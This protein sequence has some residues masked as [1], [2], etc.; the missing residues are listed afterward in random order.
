[1]IKKILFI[2][3]T[4]SFDGSTISFLNLVKDIRKLNIEV[5]VVYKYTKS[6]PNFGGDSDLVK[7]LKK[8]GCKTIGM[9]LP[10]YNSKMNRG[11]INLIIDVSKIIAKKILSYRKLKRLFITENPDIVH[12]NNDNIYDGY[13]V[14]RVLKIPHIWHMREY[15]TLD[16]NNYILPS[17]KYFE[18]LLKG[19]YTV[20]IT[21]DIKK[22]YNLDNDKKDFVFYNPTL[23]SEK[24]LEIYN[25]NKY[26]LVANRLCSEKGIEDIIRAFAV[27]YNKHDNYVLKLL[28]FEPTKGYVDKLRQLCE[29]L[30]ITDSVEFLGYTEDV[31]SYMSNANAL[32]V[33]SYYEGFGR[34]TAEANM[35][36]LPV[37][38]RNT[39]GTKEI[40]ELTGGGK[41][42][43]TI[44]EM[45]DCMEYFAAM[46]T[47]EIRNFMEK[48]RKIA[49][50]SF[51]N[52]QHFEK[53]MK[54]YQ[55]CIEN[56]NKRL[57]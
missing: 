17:K 5:T 20:S 24:A 13:L 36:G 31:C 30:N 42:F 39:G 52:E 54:L 40:L 26:F 6:L 45:A 27:F 15:Q 46:T 33:G 57:E 7:E 34:M 32:I 56:R 44:E 23:S 43:N 9:W 51:S 16:F 11:I 4:I 19:S 53:M 10:I 55:L 18:K 1:M 21:N 14:S 22:F 12:T 8:I 35:L 3:H 50:E 47:E 41:T 25:K 28:G 48:P 38:G 37:I 29:Y 49:V 2:I